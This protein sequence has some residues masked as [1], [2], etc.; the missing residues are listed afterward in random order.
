MRGRGVEKS[1]LDLTLGLQRLGADLHLILRE[2]ELLLDVGEVKNLHILQKSGEVTPEH[3]GALLRRLH[4]EKP[5]DLIISSNLSFLE[6]SGFTHPNIWYSVNMSWGTRLLKRWRF[7]KW[8]EVRK[9]YTGKKI[10]A[11]SEGVKHD[12]LQTLRVKPAAI[13]VIYDPYNISRIQRLA[14]EAIEPPANRPYIVHV[15]AFDKIKRHDLLLEAFAQISE[16]VDLYLIGE[17]RERK[18]IEK[19]AKRLGLED[20]VFFPGWQKNPYP[21]IANAEATVLSSDSEALP[22]VLIESLIVGTTPVSTDCKYGPSEILRGDLARFLAKTGDPA[23][24]A[25]KIDEA[26]TRPA[27][28]EPSCYEAFDEKLILQK[29]LKLID[30]D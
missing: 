14:A 30:I 6:K 3:L 15:G 7:R 11:V 17:G 20:R 29:Y 27:K 19:L 8:L 1:Y 12:L 28:I 10:I 16:N 25:R 13:E 21:W 24:L 5:I 26:L 18:R 9:E 2:S 22:R 23:D 4:E